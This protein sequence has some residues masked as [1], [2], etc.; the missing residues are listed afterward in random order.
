MKTAK[1]VKRILSCVLALIMAMSVCLIPASAADDATVGPLANPI[2][3]EYPTVVVRGM[4]FGG[5]YLNVGTDEQE[6]L[7][8]EF[9][10]GELMSAIGKTIWSGVTKF[11]MDAAMDEVIAYVDHLLG[12]LAC[13]ADGNSVYDA[14]PILYPGNASKYPE[15]YDSEVIGAEEGIVK[16]LAWRYGPE[17]VYY[18]VYDWRLNPL[19]NADDLE[20]TIQLAMSEHN[21][22]KV[23]IVCASMGGMQT[24]S[25]MSK[26]GYDNINSILF[27]SAAFR[28]AYVPSDC[29]RGK[30]YIGDD[31]LYNFVAHAVEGNGFA[32]S[33]VT[34]AKYSGVFK[35][36][37][38]IANKFVA[39][40]QQKVVDDFLVET[41]G[42]LTGFWAL[43][44]VENFEECYKFMFE[45]REEEYAGVA[46]IA[47][48]LY[49]MNCSAEEM[50]LEA[51]ESVKIGVSAHYDTPLI[52]VYERACA[53]GDGILE[54]GAV[55]GGATIADYGK[56]LDVEEG[57]YVSP[58]KVVDA[59]TAMFP[60]YTW[61][62]KDAPH[63]PGRP[64][65]D[66]DDFITWFL[67]YEGQPTVDSNAAYPQFMIC[68]AAEKLSIM[69]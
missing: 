50:L 34:A 36:A 29:M 30:I 27:V 49:E 15:L 43:V 37:S 28:G 11:S 23:N 31:T 3:P 35:I 33:L 1:T 57:R 60:D 65:G 16:S 47:R 6:G 41:L 69:E 64:D 39:K 63:V 10:F 55:S 61:F 26:Y 58:D 8:R 44:T 5:L 53:N 25:Y 38:V 68:D 46:A 52:P 54:T 32:S 51:A 22:D 40:Y 17:H 56:T 67:E 4:N 62:I 66:Y 24:V 13:D 45:G 20:A 12:R 59:S 48:E 2:D 19:D 42:T 7:I 9:N 14:S 18:Y 21:C